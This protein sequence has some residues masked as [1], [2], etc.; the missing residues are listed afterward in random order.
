MAW[1][2]C[3]K[4]RERWTKLENHELK[5]KEKRKKQMNLNESSKPRLIF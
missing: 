4:P 1:L 5:K 3:A 2:Q